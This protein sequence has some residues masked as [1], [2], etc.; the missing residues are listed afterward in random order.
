MRSKIR[1][2]GG[3][4]GGGEGVLPPRVGDLGGTPDG[5]GVGGKGLSFP[6]ETTLYC[7]GSPQEVKQIG[8]LP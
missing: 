4:W 1:G 7:E 3:W 5:V 6:A 8:V 2:A